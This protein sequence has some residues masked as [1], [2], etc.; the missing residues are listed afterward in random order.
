MIQVIVTTVEKR[1]D[2]K[3]GQWD[4][5]TPRYNFYRSCTWADRPTRVA[6][7]RRGSYRCLPRTSHLYLVLYKAARNK[8]LQSQSVW[9]ISPG[10]LLVR[11]ND[12]IEKVDKD[13]DLMSWLLNEMSLMKDKPCRLGFAIETPQTIKAIAPPTM[14]NVATL[15]TNSDPIFFLK[16]KGRNQYSQDGFKIKNSCGV[17]RDWVLDHNQNENCGE[18]RRYVGDDVK[19]RS[20]WEVGTNIVHIILNVQSNRKET[21]NLWKYIPSLIC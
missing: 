16:I 13:E 10:W 2:D 18:I 12:K 7:P 5:G 21:L 9:R 14:K 17:S 6:A 4:M 3:P 1:H 8:T 20:N 15:S 19:E 11:K